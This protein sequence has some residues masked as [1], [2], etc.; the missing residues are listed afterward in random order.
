MDQASTPL[1]TKLDADN[2]IDY[3]REIDTFIFDA[4]GVLWLGDSA[5]P[6]SARTID[7]LLGL[8]K[9][10]IVLTNNAT[11]SRASYAKKL[12]KLGF[13]AAINKELI[14]NPAAVAAEVL[15]LAGFRESD[16]KV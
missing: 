3:I 16:K 10:V 14:V 12:V 5:I 6:G 15:S 9:L 11:K 4:D 8:K 13:P 1:P 7:Y 2:F